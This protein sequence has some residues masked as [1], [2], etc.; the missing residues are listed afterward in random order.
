MFEGAGKR[1]RGSSARMRHSSRLSTQ[2]VYK[3][4]VQARWGD[5]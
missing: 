3:K 1:V 4:Q 2:L 5:G